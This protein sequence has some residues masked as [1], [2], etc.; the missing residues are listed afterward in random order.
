MRTRVKICGITRPEDAVCAAQLGAD[1]IGLV[2]FPRSPRAVDIHR[3]VEIAGC[4]PPF[5]TVVGLFVDA[6]DSRVE[7]VLEAVPVS[8]L[9][10]HGRESAAYCRRF[11]QPYVK[12][13]AMDGE[14]D[15]QQR[16]VAYP[17]ASGFLLD[18]YAKGLAGGTGTTFDWSRTPTGLGVPIILAGGL[19]PE[20]IG[21]A[22]QAVHPYG[23]DVSS[24]V[25]SAKG[26]KDARRMAAFLQEVHRVDADQSRGS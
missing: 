10:F 8:L 7:A 26:I 25:E 2:F 17:D 6:P 18:A 13:F 9:Q 24:G 14:T 1:A 23:V 15:V 4:L 22:I 3:A 12:A 16:A 21:G 11:G 19:T 5:V 20:N